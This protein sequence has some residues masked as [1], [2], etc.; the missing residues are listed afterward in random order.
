MVIQKEIFFEKSIVY[1]VLVQAVEKKEIFANEEDCWRFVF[2][3]YAANIGRPAKNLHRKEVMETAQALL[4]MGR[5]Y[6][7]K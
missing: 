6:Q 3:I 1:H 7:K 4:Y 5:K 2:Q